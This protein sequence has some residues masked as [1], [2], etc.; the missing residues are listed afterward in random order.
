MAYENAGSEENRTD[1][2]E[3]LDA[4]P[5]TDP[6]DG[7]ETPE[8]SWTA[9]ELPP[10]PEWLPTAEELGFK[11]MQNAIKAE[12]YMGEKVWAKRK[13]SKLSMSGFIKTLGGRIIAAGVLVTV[14]FGT[15]RVFGKFVR[16]A[17]A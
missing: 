12:R 7:D 2:I 6:V 15:G 8:S 4:E 5:S 9:P 17:M 14:T 16:L 3:N 1:P 11:K 10:L 13:R